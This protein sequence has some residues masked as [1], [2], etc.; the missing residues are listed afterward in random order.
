M[1]LYNHTEA[2]T[3]EKPLIPNII[4]KSL[5][6]LKENGYNEEEQYIIQ[7]YSLTHFQKQFIESINKIN[8]KTYE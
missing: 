2:G 5:I 6:W 4:F 8:R 1:T 3:K 7:N